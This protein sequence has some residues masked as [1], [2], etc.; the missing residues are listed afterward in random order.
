M[1]KISILGSTGSIGT[2]CLDVIDSQQDKFE[3]QYLTANHNIQLLFDQAKKFRPKAVSVFQKE[4]IN[5]YLPKFKDIG[6]EVYPGFQGILE[7]SRKDDTDILVNA[8]VG[9]V[10]LQPTLNAIKQNRRIALANKETLVIGGQFV[11]EKIKNTGAELIPIDSEHSALLQC[12]TGERRTNIQSIFLTASGGP[13]RNVSQ[14][15]FPQVTVEQ[16]LNHPNWDMGQKITID[17]ATL[18]NKG[19]EVIEAHWLFSLEALKIKVLIH[20]QSIIH[21]MV[22]FEDGSIKAQLGIPDMRI[23]IQYA[24]T[25]PERLPTDLP[26]VNFLDVKELTFEKPDMDKFTCLGLSYQALENG[27]AS[28]TVLNAANE[29][30]VILFLARKIRFDQIPQIVEDALTHC[31]F[32]SFHKVE[33]LLQYDK[34]TREYIRNKYCFT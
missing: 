32:T 5:S 31:Q 34:I 24:L 27:G 19:L 23:P 15:E 4:E 17:S 20:P 3:V 11:I 8:L 25:Y 22:E 12:L 30:A 13:L 33:E 7:I 6:V 21:S 16:A 9:A 14:R 18:M 26:R 2:N 10:G 28:P 29:E 1:K